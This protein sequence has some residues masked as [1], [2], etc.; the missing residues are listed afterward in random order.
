MYN[1]VIICYI[2]QFFYYGIIK[3]SS[4]KS[5]TILF[6][7]TR[8]LISNKIDG[9]DGCQIVWLPNRMVAKSYGC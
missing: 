3:S 4:T 5:L 2:I 7:H 1:D 9:C 8:S 6:G